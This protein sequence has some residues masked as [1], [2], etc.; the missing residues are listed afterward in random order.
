[1]L[2]LR[3]DQHE[4]FLIPVMDRLHERI[5]RHLATHHSDCL[6]GLDAAQVRARIAAATGRARRFGLSWE[7]SLL[8]Y[9]TLTFR[10]GADFHTQDPMT[11]ELSTVSAQSEPDIAFAALLGRVDIDSGS[12]AAPA[13]G[14]R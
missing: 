6:A 3:A 11:E 13:S 7:L 8:D 5:H 9:T 10:L 14:G 2:E 1:M 4:L 12:I